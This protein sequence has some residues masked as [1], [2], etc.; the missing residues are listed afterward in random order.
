LSWIISA[1]IFGDV[2]GG[3]DPPLHALK[4]LA[5]SPQCF[6]ETGA[7]KQSPAP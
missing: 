5:F 7:M 2:G 6:V 4:S 1:G 3:S